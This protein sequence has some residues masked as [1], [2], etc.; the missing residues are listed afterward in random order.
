MTVTEILLLR[1]VYEL[2]ASLPN[3]TFA[4]DHGFEEWLIHKGYKR[5]DC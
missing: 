4:R 2:E 1:R 5:D 3:R